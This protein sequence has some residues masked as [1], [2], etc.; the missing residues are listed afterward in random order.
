[1][2]PPALRTEMRPVAPSPRH[3]WIRGYWGWQ[4]GRHVWMGGHWDEPPAPG[5]VWVDA[6]WANENG[7]WV[8]HPGYWEPVAAPP[9]PP[10]PPAPVA[11]YADPA[12]AEVNIALG[13]PPPRRVEVVPRQP[14]TGYLWIEGDWIWDGHQYRWASGRWEAPRPGWMWVPPQ[15]QPAGAHYRWRPGHWRRR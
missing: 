8:F 15:W 9:P 4:D 5:R 3:I 2:P 14:G 11:V 7:E 13:P 1:V 12:I 10:P 6:R